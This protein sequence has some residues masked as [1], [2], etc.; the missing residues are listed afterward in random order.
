[1]MCPGYVLPAPVV[2]RV[3]VCTI[4]APKVTVKAKR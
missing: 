3:L 1:M 2:R 4:V